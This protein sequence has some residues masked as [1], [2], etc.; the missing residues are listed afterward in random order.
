MS[1]SRPA[2]FPLLKLPFLCI[3]CVIKNWRD[4]FDTISFALI[5]KRTR[6]IVKLLKIP[7][8]GIEIFVSEQKMIKL[9]CLYKIW[10]F[11]MTRLES[12]FLRKYPIVL[13]DNAIPLLTRRTDYSLESYTHGT[14]VTALK[15]AMEFLNEVFKCSVENVDIK[16]IDFPESFGVNSTV[17]LFVQY[18]TPN[19]KMMLLLE[20]L[21]V[22]G[23]CI[24]FGGNNAGTEFFCDPKLFKCKKLVFSSSAWV[25][26]EI[27]LQFE[28]SQLKFTECSFSDEDIAAFVTKWFYSDCRTFE[29]LYVLLQDRQI[30]REA[31]QDL[32]PLPFSERNR[33]LPSETF[34]DVDFSK[35]LEIVRHDGAPGLLYKDKRPN[36]K[37]HST[38]FPLDEV[39]Q[40]THSFYQT[41]PTQR[42]LS[43]G[44]TEQMSFSRPVK[45]PLL[46][47]PFLC[48]ECVVRSCKGDIFDIIF[49]ALTSKRARQIVKRLKIPLNGIQLFVSYQKWI[50]LGCPYKSWGFKDE[51]KP[52]QF[53]DAHHNLRRH[54]FVLQKDSAPLYTSKTDFSLKSYTDGSEVLA[55]KMAMDFL[56]EVFICS[57]EAV[58]LYGGFF[59]EPGDIG[60]RSTMN[61]DVYYP[62][63]QKFRQDQNQ[64]L[65]L[66]LENLQVTGTCTF[67]MERTESGFYCDPKL[68]KCKTTQIS[69]ENF[70]TEELNPVPF[71]GRTR[72]PLSESF[73]DVDFSKGLEIVRHDGLVATIYVT[74]RDFLFYIWHTQ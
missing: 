58:H 50:R 60:I 46:K 38:F 31:F 59:P 3:E 65:N 29:Y 55:V 28:V 2:K 42:L 62:K 36:C 20:N 51:N 10:S 40:H 27:L 4:I 57:V 74:G 8:T 35:G 72:V 7:L 9:G 32:S 11:K 43:A 52:I 47:L 45:F 22:T 66:L 41:H 49:F 34:I 15:M 30:S 37:H 19:P 5:S 24:F 73:K 68:L 21:K 26:R 63:T 44:N 16:D 48:I 71:I 12:L 67:L 18:V 1:L 53:Y 61:L 23:T 25:T 69:L 13:Q 64:R 54:P 56:N 17:N 39:T 70:H 6:R 33:V 14:E